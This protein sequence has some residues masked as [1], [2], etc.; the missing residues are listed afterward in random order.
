MSVVVVRFQTGSCSCWMGEPA[1]VFQKRHTHKNLT[2]YLVTFALLF[3][4]K[5]QSVK[6]Q[7]VKKQGVKKPSGQH[8]CLTR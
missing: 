4:V 6:K 3:H 2:L 8:G 1:K 5:K 7:S